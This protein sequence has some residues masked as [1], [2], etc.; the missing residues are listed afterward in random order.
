[1]VAFS[2]TD[3]QAMTSPQVV[4]VG[5]GV[6][7]LSIAYALGREGIRSVVC[8]QGELGRA[9][10]WAGAGIIAPGPERPPTLPTA[11]LRALSARLHAEWAE[12]L[13]SETDID[14]GY[15][16]TG[17]VDVAWDDLEDRDLRSLAGRWRIEGIAF[18]RLEP[19]DFARVEPALN[20]ELRVAYYVPDRAQIRNP[21]HV[22]ALIAAC[23][24]RGAVL[25]PNR[26][27]TGFESSDGR[28]SAVQTADGALPCD[29]VVVAA[30]PWTESLLHGLD[31]HVPTSPVKG[32]IVLLQSDKPIVRR[33]I[34]HGKNYLVPRDDGRVL[35][36]STEEDAGFDPRPTAEGV[37]GLISEALRLCPSLASCHFERAWGG[38]RPGSVDL[39][40]YIGLAPGFSNLIVASGHKR[41]GLQLSPGTA[42][43]VADLVLGRTPEIDLGAFAPGR[44]PAPEEDELFRS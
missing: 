20:P 4:I 3:G 15:R 32:Q 35:V 37:N 2:S 31:V 33:I 40:P 24:R 7:G 5:G 21:W 12:T 39:K 11:A 1:V 14:N 26:A 42:V 9:A 13:R 6:V 16:R 8:D 23:E 36:G 44:R 43:L 18:E 10:S 17:G 22:R 34:E 25:Y 41:A 19:R 30:G 27:A 29:T 38:L 28:V